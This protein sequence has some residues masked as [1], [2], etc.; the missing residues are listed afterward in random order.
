MLVTVQSVGLLR[1]EE[2]RRAPDAHCTVVR[3]GRHE[4]RDGRVPAHA[5]HRARVACQLGDG[6]LAAAVPDVHLV[7]WGGE[8]KTGRGQP[9]R[10]VSTGKSLFHGR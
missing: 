1:F 9:D 5:V 10:K 4:P 2:W 6:Q 8:S 7:V 3:G